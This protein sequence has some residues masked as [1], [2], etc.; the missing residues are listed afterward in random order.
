[1]KIM[2]TFFITPS[3]HISLGIYYNFLAEA[4][5]EANKLNNN[6]IWLNSENTKRFSFIIT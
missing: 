5:N 2:V 1:M 3:K 4:T 6:K